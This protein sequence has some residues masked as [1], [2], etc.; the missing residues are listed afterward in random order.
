MDVKEGYAITGLLCSFAP[1]KQE[2][3]KM[4]VRGRREF[5]VS[6]KTEY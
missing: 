3:G 2:Y 4:K 5:T 1:R 6:S